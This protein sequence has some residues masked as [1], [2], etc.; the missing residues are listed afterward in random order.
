MSTGTKTQQIENSF[1]Y[2]PPTGDQAERYTT[3]RNTAKA[4]AFSIDDLVPDGREK[5]VAITKLEEAIMWANKGIACSGGAGV[6]R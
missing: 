1:T 2:H 3:L 5:S 6:A 4:L